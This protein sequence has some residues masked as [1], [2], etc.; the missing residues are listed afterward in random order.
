MT[1]DTLSR[2]DTKRGKSF[3]YRFGV[4]IVR[5]KVMAY[6]GTEV[7]FFAPTDLQRLAADRSQPPHFHALYQAAWEC[8]QQN[9][10]VQS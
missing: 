9:G 2:R 3:P 8:W 1:P 5:R 10:V 4:D 6:N 7:K